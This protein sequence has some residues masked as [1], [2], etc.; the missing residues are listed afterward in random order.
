MGKSGGKNNYVHL[1]SMLI[2]VCA[3][4]NLHKN[5]FLNIESSTSKE[6]VIYQQQK[7]F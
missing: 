3:V 1:S 2:H 4:K 7:S 5:I 6:T